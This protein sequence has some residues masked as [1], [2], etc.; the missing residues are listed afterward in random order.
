[1][2]RGFFALT[3]HD[4]PRGTASTR[5]GS[6]PGN[7]MFGP[8][9][10]S[11]CPPRGR[12]GSEPQGALLNLLTDFANRT[13]DLTPG[14]RVQVHNDSE[15]MTYTWTNSQLW[16]PGAPQPYLRPAQSETD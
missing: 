12:L 5:S 2:L 9:H 14:D 11:L 3:T 8:F 7:R 13:P 6:Q 4:E 1:M 15:Y 10:C 16:D